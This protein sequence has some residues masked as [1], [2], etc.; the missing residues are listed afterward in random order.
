M[1][2]LVVYEDIKTGCRGVC[3]FFDVGD[4]SH[5][6]FRCYI[7]KSSL[8]VVVNRRGG[9]TT[10]EGETSEVWQGCRFV[11]FRDYPES[12]S[13]DFQGIIALEE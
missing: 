10:F 12:G 9:Y 6:A 7:R 11:E 1:P 2:K 4:E 13:Y 8:P 5:P 3:E